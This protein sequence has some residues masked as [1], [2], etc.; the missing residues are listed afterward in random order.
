MVREELTTME[1]T[2]RV[3]T[4][5]ASAAMNCDP[6]QDCRLE[7]APESLIIH[8]QAPGPA[9]RV[10]WRRFEVIQAADYT[11]RLQGSMVPPMVISH[12]GYQFEDAL[13]RMRL[14][15]SL[16]LA[17]DLL[18]QEEVQQSYRRFRIRSPGSEPPGDGCLG[19][20]HITRTALIFLPEEGEPRRIPAAE[21]RSI[22]RENHSI[23]LDLGNQESLLLER[24]GNQLDPLLR[25]TDFMIR[26]LENQT[27][28]WLWSFWPDPPSDELEAATTL[29]FDGRAAPY[30][31]IRSLAPSL[32]P[33][34]EEMLLSGSLAGEYRFLLSQSS[35][36]SLSIG[37]KQGLWGDRES[38][39]VWLLLFFPESRRVVLE[40]GLATEQPTEDSDEPGKASYFF[41][42]PDS[43]PERFARA[44]R[45]INFR[46][47]PIYL[48]QNQL[49]SPR[50]ESYRHSVRRIPELRELRSLYI[51]RVPHRNPEQW[52]RDCLRVIAPD[53]SRSNS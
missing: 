12:L 39:Y 19:D 18:F 21:I 15:R 52:Q 31:R 10:S 37:F 53:G 4:P 3:T 14:Y 16:Q 49:D 33:R 30:S 20:L 29:L 24:L 23:R 44:F 46:R 45:A 36:E 28:E 25:D 50:Y 6:S 47:E 42:A 17:R 5:A 26:R 35:H 51:T 13:R 27:R 48:N 8:R 32:W 34:L 40:A 11:I 43:D 7:I 41:Q 38:N 9:V 1:C 2:G 22:H